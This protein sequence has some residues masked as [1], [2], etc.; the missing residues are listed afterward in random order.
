MILRENVNE[1]LYPFMS[2]F[3]TTVIFPK[4]RLIDN[5]WIPKYCF[6]VLDSDLKLSK[7]VSKYH[8]VGVYLLFAVA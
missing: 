7:I 1:R 8:D 3:H 5:I 4:L 2:L 6:I